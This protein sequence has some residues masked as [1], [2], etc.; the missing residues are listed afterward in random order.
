MRLKAV[1]WRLNEEF[2]VSENCVNIAV[3]QLRLGCMKGHDTPDAQMCNLV[4]PPCWLHII[5]HCGYRASPP[6]EA[7]CRSRRLFQGALLVGNIRRGS[8]ELSLPCTLRTVC[9]T[10]VVVGQASNAES[11]VF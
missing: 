10:C 1:S 6:G 4:C 9:K 7:L 2:I 5:Q 8:E 11:G 3:I